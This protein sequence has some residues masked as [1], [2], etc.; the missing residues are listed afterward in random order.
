MSEQIDFFRTRSRSTF[1]GG[2]SSGADFSDCGKYRYKLWR[3]WNVHRDKLVVIML[4]PS[5]ADAVQDDP[6]VRR[7]INRARAMNLG[8]LVVL[9]LFAYRT[10]SPED[11]KRAKDPIGPYNDGFILHAVE[12]AKM[13]ICG[14]GVHGGHLSRDWEVLD[15]LRASDIKMHALGITKDGHPRHPLY[16]PNAAKPVR[17]GGD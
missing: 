15:L 2:Q 4:N 7:M 12:G 8:G 6:T 3:T 1:S 13:V 11:M 14:W 16:I 9:N 17:F 10:K 5:T